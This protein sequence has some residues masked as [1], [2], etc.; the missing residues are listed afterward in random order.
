[1]IFERSNLKLKICPVLVVLL[2][3]LKSVCSSGQNFFSIML[4]LFGCEINIFLVI[5]SNIILK[6]IPKYESRLSGENS[7]H[8][9]TDCGFCSSTICRPVAHSGGKGTTL[10][11]ACNML[12]V[13][14]TL[15]R[16]CPFSLKHPANVKINLWS[17]IG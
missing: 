17:L 5:L 16:T 4:K 14:A 3:D 2:C 8:P 9:K 12:Y 1:M 15:F 7:C 6:K 13:P 10:L 11:Y